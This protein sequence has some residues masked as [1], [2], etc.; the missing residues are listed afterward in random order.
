MDYKMIYLAK[1]NP[2]VAPEDWPRTWRT[3][4]KFVSQFPIIGA[5]IDHL[6]YCARLREPTLDGKA[7]DPPGVSREYDGVAVVASDDGRLHTNAIPKDIYE[8]ILDDERRVFSMNVEQFSVQCREASVQ[9]ERRGPAA[10]IRFVARKPGTSKEAFAEAFQAQEAAAER[11]IA[12]GKTTR[13]VRNTVIAEPPPGYEYDA[14]LETWFDSA[15]AATRSFADPDLAPL[16]RDLP[17]ACD[18]AKAVT[19]L[20]EVIYALPRA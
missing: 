17:A 16:V 13:Q 19:M 1:R 9:G 10:V 7:F 4:P 14:V 20:T 3:H 18:P 2:T 12:A 11:A 8:Q 15:E 5:A 6:N